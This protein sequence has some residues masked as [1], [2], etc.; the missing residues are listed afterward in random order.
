[1]LKN[2]VSNLSGGQ[3]QM[4]AFII[5]T[6]MHPQLLILDE[7]TAALDP[8][9]SDNLL[10]LIKTMLSPKLITLMIT[11]DLEQAVQLGNKIWI[12]KNGIISDVIDK[13][14]IFINSEKLKEL[15]K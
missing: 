13:N 4:L 11:H 9:S 7:P 10:A 14:E 5:A 2:K 6:T 12:M 1:M 15:L 3:R 8:I